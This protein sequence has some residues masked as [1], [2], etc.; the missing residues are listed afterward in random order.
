MWDKDT[1][2]IVSALAAVASFIVSLGAL[3]IAISGTRSSVSIA[4]EALQSARQANDIALG[5]LRE[6]SI[7]E[8]A[9]RQNSEYFKFDFTSTSALVVPLKKTLTIHNTGKTNIES[10]AIEAIGIEPFTYLLTDPAQAVSPLPSVNMDVKLRMALPPDGLAHI[11]VRKLI[12]EYLSLLEPQLS[13]KGDVYSTSINIV[14]APK[15]INES[16]A[17]GASSQHTKNDRRLVAVKFIPSLVNTA[18]AQS[19]LKE[20]KAQTRVLAP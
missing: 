16:I 15:S 7:V 1:W 11:D 13:F 18:E 10:I 4:A 9:F 14:L 6:P 19:V 8:Y 17:I 5:C 2:D 20:L 12:L 3:W